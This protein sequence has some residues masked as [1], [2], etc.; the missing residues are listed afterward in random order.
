[1]KSD[2]PS[3][4]LNYISDIKIRE[5]VRELINNY[6]PCKTKTTNL[7]MK[8]VLNDEKPIHQAPRRFPPAEVIERQTEQWI[9]EGK[10]RPSSSDYASPVVVTKRMNGSPRV[11]IDYRKLNRVIVRDRYPLSVIEDLIDKLQEARV[12]STIDLKNGFLHVSVSEESRKYTAFVTQNGQFDFLNMPFGLC[13][14][15]SVFQRFINAV[16]KSLIKEGICFI[17][18]DDI[19]IPAPNY[20]ENV[21][22]LKRVF[23]TASEYG[24]EINKRKVQLMKRRIEFLGHMIEDGKVYPSP[25]KIKAILDYPAPTCVKD[26]QS[27]LGLTSN[28]RKFIPNHALIAKPLSDLLQKDKKFQFDGPEQRSFLELKV[29]MMKDLVLLIYNP[30]LETELHTDASREGYGAILMQ[31][32]I[33][34]QQFHPVHYMSRKTTS[35]EKNYSSYEL[36]V[37]AVIMALKKFRIYL[38]GIKFK[39]ITDCVAFQKTINKKD[40]AT[41]VARWFLLLEEFDYTVEHRPGVR[42]KHVDALSRYPVLTFK[43]DDVIPRIKRAQQKDSETNVILEILKEKSFKDYFVRGDLLYVEKDGRDVLVVPKAMQTDII[44]NAH[45]R[46]HFAVL[47]TEELIKQ[48]YFIPDLRRKVEKYITNCVPCIL[49]NRKQGKQEGF[50]HPITKD[51][52]PLYTYHVDHLGPLETTSKR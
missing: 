15:P 41:R 34:D 40:L 25:D 31:K 23:E 21:S 28:F 16:F 6:V 19:I 38:L 37:L 36:E 45:D 12:F 43:I 11:C 49:G 44:R 24:L 9:E 10:I 30:K 33:E 7:E 1:M 51:D 48:D 14:A 3:L 13:N 8:I 5:E 52:Q 29:S 2:E 20:D 47:R 18:I 50:L 35:A 27:F 32:S 26:I 46:G 22:R 39:I 4:D 17:Y 42:M